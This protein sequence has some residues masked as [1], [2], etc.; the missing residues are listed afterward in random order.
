MDTMYLACFECAPEGISVNVIDRDQRY[1]T[2]MQGGGLSVQDAVADAMG[3]RH[4]R[5]L[6]EHDECDACK[7]AI[8]GRSLIFTLDD[9][10]RIVSQGML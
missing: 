2:C 8:R 4:I 3:R 6:T 7:A 5:F 10:G 9:S 1:S